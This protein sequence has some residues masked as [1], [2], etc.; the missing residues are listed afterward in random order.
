MENTWNV[1]HDTAIQKKARQPVGQKGLTTLSMGSLYG[2]ASTV[3]VSLRLK[4]SP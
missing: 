1:V 3:I 4:Q 2:L